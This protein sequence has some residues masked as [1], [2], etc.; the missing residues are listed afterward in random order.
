MTSGLD[1]K[2]RADRVEQMRIV[3]AEA[4]NVLKADGGKGFTPAQEEELLSWA[5]VEFAA[6]ENLIASAQRTILAIHPSLNDDKEKLESETTMYL[7]QSMSTLAAR[8]GIPIDVLMK[9]AVVYYRNSEL[10]GDP[11][12]D[13]RV[14]FENLLHGASN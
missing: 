8:T 1:R 5:N 6:V 2:S 4:K 12:E 11:E 7:V 3:L 9:A 10:V 13:E 14:D